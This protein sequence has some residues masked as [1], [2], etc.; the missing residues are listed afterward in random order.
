MLVEAFELPAA[1]DD[2]A[3]R[4]ELLFWIG[5]ALMLG[6]VPVPE[7]RA[8]VEALRVHV[9]TPLEEAWLEFPLAV[10]AAL[11]GEFEESRRLFARSRGTMGEAGA[12]VYYAAGGMFVAACLLLEGA[13]EEAEAAARE[14]WDMLGAVGERGLRSTVGTHVAQALMVLGRDEEAE[15]IADEAVALTNDADVT[16]QC[17]YRL[18]LARLR[19]RA[20]RDDE[21]VQLA[22][23][24]VDWALRAD[25]TWHHIDA[26]LALA[27]VAGDAAAAAE[28][29]RLID[30]HGAPALR[31]S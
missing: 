13:A 9:K 14:G 7:A 25:S 24:G 17:Y 20:G 21:A 6:P 22:R 26:Y 29:A 30:A 19:S 31:P 4:G 1:M 3:I 28:A 8:R 15:A 16:T 27:E 11:S 23:E 5:A 10:L 12:Q 18:V 2:P